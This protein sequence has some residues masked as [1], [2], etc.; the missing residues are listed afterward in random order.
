MT[1]SLE[2]LQAARLKVCLDPLRV[3][4]SRE[5]RPAPREWARGAAI[6]VRG[7]EEFFRS[8]IGSKGGPNQNPLSFAKGPHSDHA[9]A[10]PLE[11]GAVRGRGRFRRH[12]NRRERTS[13]HRAERESGEARE[14]PIAEGIGGKP[15]EGHPPLRGR[16][17]PE[18]S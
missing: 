18:G 4:E 14:P 6:R 15:G 17:W 12:R 1:E 7:G 9:G 11:M 16:A 8:L 2:I 13:R 5:E 10:A 3:K